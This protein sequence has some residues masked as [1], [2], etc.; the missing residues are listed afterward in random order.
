MNQDLLFQCLG[1]TADNASPNNVM[2]DE[3]VDMLPN[4]PGQV[5]HCHCFLHIVNLIA[6]TLL[7]QFDV[8]TKDAESALDDAEK[9]L[10]ELA[11]G[12]DM[13]EM[14]TVA[15]AGAGDKDDDK[16]DDVEG[17]VDEMALLSEE[18]RAALRENVGPVR[19]VLMKVSEC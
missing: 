16:N 10:L 3:L 11:A 4:F 9:E 13:E 14:V 2:I 19:L 7:K 18:E 6:K 5:N 17:W 1:V 12:I 8:P 15:Q